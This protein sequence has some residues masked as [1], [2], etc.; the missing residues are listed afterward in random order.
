MEPEQRKRVGQLIKL[1]RIEAGMKQQDLAVALGV[2]RISVSEWERGIKQHYSRAEAIALEDALHI[3]DRRLLLAL[4]Y[5]RPDAAVG[6]NTFSYGG[7]ELGP[8]EEREVLDYI[9]WLRTRR[10]RR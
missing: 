4:G 9:E 7:D 1:A 5:E 8:L 6:R 3:S 10:D 2:S